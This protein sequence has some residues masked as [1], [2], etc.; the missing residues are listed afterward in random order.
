MIMGFHASDWG[1]IYTA[2]TL[3][4]SRM[5]G[6]MFVRLEGSSRTDELLFERLQSNPSCDVPAT[7]DPAIS[8]QSG[9]IHSWTSPNHV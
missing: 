2:E 3:T 9:S 5:D 4:P 1:Q 7:E 6:E 8:L